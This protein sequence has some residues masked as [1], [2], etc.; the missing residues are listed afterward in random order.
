MNRF[1]IAQDR[2]TLSGKSILEQSIDE[3]GRE[4]PSLTILQKVW[5]LIGVHYSSNIA[6][7]CLSQRIDRLSILEHKF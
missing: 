2:L 6:K 4:S 3:M 1:I 7:A 5:S